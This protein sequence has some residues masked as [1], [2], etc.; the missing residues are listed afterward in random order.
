MRLGRVVVGRALVARTAI[1]PRAIGQATTNR[2]R[3]QLV[4]PPATFSTS[5]RRPGPISDEALKTAV[6]ADMSQEMYHQLADGY[7]ENIL[8]ALEAEQ[9]KSPHIDVEYSVRFISH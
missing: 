2:T 8:N 7:L 9:E 5:A 1:L 6:A 4:A 3:A